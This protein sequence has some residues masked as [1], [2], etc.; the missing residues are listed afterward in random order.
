MLLIVVDGGKDSFDQ[1]HV[2]CNSHDHPV[3][4]AV[5]RITVERQPPTV[6]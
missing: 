6:P 1:F 3:P 4:V 2:P 5:T